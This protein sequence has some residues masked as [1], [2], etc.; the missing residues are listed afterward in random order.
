MTSPVG[1]CSGTLVDPEWVLSAAHCGYVAN[2]PASTAT[3]VRPTGDVTR[4]IDDVRRFPPP[5]DAMLVH[6]SAPFTDLPTAQ[7]Y[8]GTHESLLNQSVSCY[9][10]GATVVGGGASSDLHFGDDL[11][12]TSVPSGYFT[13]LGNSAN[14]IMLGGDSGG[15][16]FFNGTLAG[17]IITYDSLDNPGRGSAV[18]V[19][20]I[21][22][23][24]QTTMA[25]V[26]PKL[27]KTVTALRD[28]GLP[29]VQANW[30]IYGSGDFDGDGTSD[31]VWSTVN[32]TGASVIWLM[33]ADGTVRSNT[34]L[35]VGASGW[36]IYG[37]GDFDGDGK[38]DLVWRRANDTLEARLWL[39]DGSTPKADIGLPNATTGWRIYGVADFDGDGIS[40]LVWR[41]ADDTGAANIWLLN[42]G[43]VKASQLMPAGGSGWRIYGTGDFNG[44]G[45]A[46]LVWR[47]TNDSAEARIWLQKDG[48][49][50]GDQALPAGGTGWR[51][52]GVGDFNADGRPDLVWRRANDTGEARIW[53]LNGRT[54]V[55]D[56]PL[57][58][59]GSG[60]RIYA[61]RDFDGNKRADI[62]WR[63]TGDTGEAR[64]W[65]IT[66]AP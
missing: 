22:D 58:A 10:F 47:R 8:A 40:D 44:D 65:T 6:L 64:I 42:A 48:T 4:Y 12:V 5:T 11:T 2:D 16:T 61:A 53:L 32:D 21:R 54:L 28:I 15:S 18:S 56:R 30:R 17:V 35:P 25:S 34:A 29:V 3:S 59:G 45:R 62:V 41:R 31:L 1:L 19:P 20:A 7:L 27:D 57:A 63:R 55:A 46:D 60:W 38:S 51:I 24:V 52:Y 9:G 26:P 43:T 49:L 66:S 23:W 39:M 37:V 13:V 50:I 14:Q 36:R 33:N